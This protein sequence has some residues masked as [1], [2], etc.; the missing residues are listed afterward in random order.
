MF[1]YV[2]FA[3]LFLSFSGI[4]ST[5]ELFPIQQSHITA[6]GA[7]TVT[8]SVF[9][10]GAPTPTPCPSTGPAAPAGK[11]WNLVFY[12]DF[13]KDTTTNTSKWTPGNMI[14]N[15]CCTYTNGTDG[16]T[17]DSVNGL[18]LTASNNPNIQQ[19]RVFLTQ[20]GGVYGQRYGLWEWSVQLPHDVNGSDGD[21]LHPDIWF[22]DYCSDHVTDCGGEDDINEKIIGTANRWYTCD[23]PNEYVSNPPCY[24]YPGSPVGNLDTSFHTYQLYWYDDGS[25]HGARVNYLDGVAQENTRLPVN[26][27]N[28]DNGIFNIL[29]EDGCYD[30]SIFGGGN[31]CATYPG[32]P[33]YNNPIMIRY[34]ASWQLVPN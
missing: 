26:Q 8:V 24:Q 28:Y 15:P 32:T 18:S 7:C 23:F 22:H 34:A 14:A 29:M 6:G 11:R 16:I 30:T 2:V 3:L 1:K 20:S 9:T 33:D 5:Q 17:F 21:G 31:A 4:G 25:A 10:S 19:F 27:A 13:T 12:D